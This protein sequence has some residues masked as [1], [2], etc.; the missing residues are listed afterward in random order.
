MKEKEYLI[1]DK[2]AWQGLTKRHMEAYLPMHTSC[3]S[4]LD[5]VS[6][7]CLITTGALLLIKQHLKEILCPFKNVASASRLSSS[8]LRR[9]AAI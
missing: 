5:C 7:Q 9:S 4:R 3:P 1:D 8:L 2:S 6:F